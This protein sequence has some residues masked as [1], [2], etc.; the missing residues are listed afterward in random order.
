M[1]RGSNTA[2]LVSLSLLC[3][4]SF[5]ISLNPQLFSS[6]PPCG[7]SF[8]ET[9]RQPLVERVTHRTP[10]VIT[11]IMSSFVL[12]A[13]LARADTAGFVRGGALRTRVGV[14]PAKPRAGPVQTK[15]FFGGG[16]PKSNGA[17]MVCIDC[18][19]S[20]PFPQCLGGCQRKRGRDAKKAHP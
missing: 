12:S 9:T 4:C 2:A 10:T 14:P 13:S 7:D 18:G 11:G 15:A 19:T 6:F 3:L 20:F 8:G 17:A 5:L 1:N 16:A